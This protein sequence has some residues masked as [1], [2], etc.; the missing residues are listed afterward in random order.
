VTRKWD[1]GEGK[2]GGGRGGGLE[3]LDQ[4]F[5]LE[6]EQRSTRDSSVVVDGGGEGGGGGGGGEGGGGGGG[7]EGGGGG[8]GFVDGIVDC[9]TQAP[10]SQVNYY[11]HSK[12]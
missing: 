3:E 9:Q 7:G 4:R 12:P 5:V 1:F 6:L 10:F 11:L 8:G 2:G